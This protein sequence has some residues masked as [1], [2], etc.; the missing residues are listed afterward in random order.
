M[1]HKSDP[2]FRSFILSFASK[3]AFGT[4]RFGQFVFGSGPEKACKVITFQRKQTAVITDADMC[5]FS[6]WF[7]L[8]N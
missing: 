1:S 6:T 8:S 2:D 4:Q 3:L 5:H 7:Y